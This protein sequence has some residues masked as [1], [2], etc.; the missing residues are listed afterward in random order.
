MPPVRTT[1][2]KK[3][4]LK[5]G[6]LLSMGFEPIS[7]QERLRD[8]AQAKITPQAERVEVDPEMGLPKPVPATERIE[9]CPS[10][11]TGSSFKDDTMEPN[12]SALTERAPPRADNPPIKKKTLLKPSN[13]EPGLK[14]VRFTHNDDWE[15]YAAVV[16]TKTRK[17]MFG[18]K[19]EGFDLEE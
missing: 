4:K 12:P 9:E 19:D 8:Q 7:R 14:E 2:S 17:L 10:S 1:D 18:S 5:N 6:S 15:D 13:Q 11:E 16:G 3:S